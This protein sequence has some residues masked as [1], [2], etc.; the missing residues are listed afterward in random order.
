MRHRLMTAI[1]VTSIT[2]LLT[3]GC[4]QQAKVD[5][6]KE[7][8]RDRLKDPNSAQFSNVKVVEGLVCGEVNA[9][10]SFGG[11]AGRQRFWG[12]KPQR[13]WG[14]KPELTFGQFVVL[15]DEP[16]T[17]CDILERQMEEARRSIANNAGSASEETTDHS[18]GTATREDFES[19]GLKWPLTATSARLGCTK[20]SR[21]AEVEGVKY[22]LNGRARSQGYE[23]T[24]PIWRIDEEMTRMIREEIERIG[25]N[26]DDEPP[27]MIDLGDMIK[28][29]GRL[30]R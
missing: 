18:I 22:A 10:N 14:G 7:A 19:R 3:T 13:F 6:V 4:G 12:G 30:C 29:A 27:M 9:K 24:E 11:Y 23:P 26:A 28:E 15:S 21:W 5:E 16:E 1:F 17:P 25:G 20:T 2:S 8:V